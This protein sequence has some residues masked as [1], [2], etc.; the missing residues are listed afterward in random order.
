MTSIG[1]I[2]SEMDKKREETELN[3]L[4]RLLEMKGEF[5]EDQVLETWNSLKKMQE[6]LELP[7]LYPMKYHDYFYSRLEE[8]KTALTPFPTAFHQLNQL[9]VEI[10]CFRDLLGL[11]ATSSISSLSVDL[12][13]ASILHKS[14][15]NFH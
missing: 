11:S 3:D 14:L 2:S 1:A 5:S 8:I 7:T 4:K 9:Y 10:N 12:M 13:K 15:I 6:E